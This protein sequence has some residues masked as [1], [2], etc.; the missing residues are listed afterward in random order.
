MAE[1][2]ASRLARY[3]LIEKVGEGGMG[4]VWRA[5]DP[6]L[7]R[8]IA[9]KVLPAR[10]AADPGR[11]SR[12]ERE[13]KL[14]ASLNHPNV[15]TIYSVE[16]END[17]HFFTMELIEGKTLKELLTKGGMTL[18]LFYELAVPLTAAVGA[19]HAKGVAHGDLKPSN[20]MVT[21]EGRVKVLDFGLAVSSDRGL[22][23]Q[24]DS[25]T[26]RTLSGEGRISGTLPYM[27]PEQIEGRGHDARSDLFSLGILLHEMLT[28]SR[29]FR[30]RSPAELIASVLKD[31]VDPPSRSNREVPRHLDRLVGRCLEKDPAHRPGSALELEAELTALRRTKT[32]TSG[33]ID[34]SIAVLP[35]AD[36]S[37]QHDQEYFCEGVADEIINAISRVESLR[38]ASRTS[39]FRFKNTTLDSREI[40]D[41]LSV[42][43]LLEG[44]V[45]K[46]GNRLRINA[47][48]VDVVDG[49][50]LWSETYDRELQDVFAIQDEIAASVV[51]AL[52]VTLSPRERRAI[53]HVATASAEAYDF[54]LRGRQLFRQFRRKSIE[55][56]QTMFAR[57]IEI[58]PTFAGAY[59]GLADCHSYL[60]MFWDVTDEHL[61][62]ADRASRKAVELD[63]DSPESYVA[64]GV[65]ISLG[66]RHEE[67]DEQFDKAI[68]LNPRMF[69]AHY[70]QGRGHYARGNKERAVDCFRRAVEARPEDYQA[71]SLLGSALAGL[72]LKVESEAA[73]RSAWELSQKHLEMFPGET[74]ALYFGALA[75]CQ[76]GERRQT[77]VELAERALALDPDE[78]QVLYNVACV[79]A[80]LGRVDEAIDCLRRTIE[81]GGW[82]KTWAKHD[83]DLVSI[84]SDARFVALVE[85]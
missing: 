4:S 51:R 18:G 2:D 56:A 82:W 25:E 17:V 60:F 38:V 69:E 52:E 16:S 7:E 20:V 41:R 83:P 43:H 34:R 74:R 8:E 10:F 64:R 22:L 6:R 66:R 55:V 58:D 57:A 40:G 71:P 53:K 31:R 84:Q 65:A 33:E 45:R 68:R 81:H 70:F 3:R 29:P 50:H 49:C 67:A 44:S 78:P 46:A 42:G 63:P 21:R 48:L 76:L 61:R 14:L 24:S 12:F 73:Y 27:S 35:F 80:V 85:S 54:Y 39:S 47:Q 11:L 79:Y 30:G 75:L 23:Q 37:E 9:L 32:A 5:L 77:A 13:A 72:G 36:M 62:E 26:T 59:A 28:G 1:L 15:V 19:A